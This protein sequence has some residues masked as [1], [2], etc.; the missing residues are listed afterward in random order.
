[1][2]YNFLGTIASIEKFEELEEMV[3]IEVRLLGRRVEHLIQEKQRYL[4]LLD[5]FKGSDAQL[6]SEY[7]LSESPD[8]DYVKKPRPREIPHSNIPDGLNASD[9]SLLKAT[10]L[11]TIKYKRERNEFKVK[12]IRDLMEQFTNEISFLESQQ[13]EYQNQLDRVRGRFDLEDF[14]EAQQ[15]AEVDPK[16]VVPG[17]AQTPKGQGQEVIDG[18]K[19]YLVLS[20][21]AGSNTITFDTAAPPVR[22]GGQ[23]KLTNGTND[24]T[25][26][27][28]GNPNS[29]SIKV[30]EIL[31]TESQSTTKVTVVS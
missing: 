8:A 22:G 6:R 4:E 2:A 29:L 12:R 23:I 5:K 9:V 10:F 1:M 26:T 27:V 20:I 24:G 31:K 14:S 21:N 3:K 25:Y 13:E 16:D 19:H 15:Y 28:Q 7:S 11:D 30:F 18:V 17:I